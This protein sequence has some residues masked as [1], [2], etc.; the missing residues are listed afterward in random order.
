MPGLF[1]RARRPGARKVKI[2]VQM[3]LIGSKSKQAMSV[4]KRCKTARNRREKDEICPTMHNHVRTGASQARP[5]ASKGV[6]AHENLPGNFPR[7]RR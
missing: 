2:T 1:E 4:E 5:I 6:P 7:E 3:N